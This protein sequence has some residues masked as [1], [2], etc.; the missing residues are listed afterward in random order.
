MPLAM[1]LT[2]PSVRSMV[3]TDVLVLVQVPPPMAS[4]RVVVPPIQILLVPLMTDGDGLTVT[5]AVAAQPPPM[6]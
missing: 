6:V 1:P 3:A 5:T 4:V 2:V